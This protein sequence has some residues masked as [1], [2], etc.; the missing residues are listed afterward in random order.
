MIGWSRQ[1]LPSYK[2]FDPKVLIVSL[3]DLF[4]PVGNTYPCTFNVVS[5][6]LSARQGM[7]GYPLGRLGSCESSVGWLSSSLCVP[8]NMRYL[9]LMGSSTFK[10]VRDRR[11]F[12][13]ERPLTSTYR[14]RP[15]LLRR[16]NSP[17]RTLPRP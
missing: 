10:H 14:W 11:S 4:F 8:Y 16:Q 3:W 7:V 5:P 15:I 9:S 6:P 17:A 12:Q 13:D 2:V 1:D